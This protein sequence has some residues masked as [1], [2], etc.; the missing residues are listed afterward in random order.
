MVIFH[1]FLY[2]YQGLK[3]M[4]YMH[5]LYVLGWSAHHLLWVFLFPMTSWGNKRTPICYAFFDVS[6][7]IGTPHCFWMIPHIFH[8][9]LSETLLFCWRHPHC[10][11]ASILILLFPYLLLLKPARLLIL[12]F[13]LLKFM[14]LVYQ[15]LKT[16]LLK[17][18]VVGKT[19][20]LFVKFDPCWFNIKLVRSYAMR[21]PP[22]VEF[23]RKP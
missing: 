3:H 22:G 5:L 23:S 12:P 20:F 15:I 10:P 6:P 14:F 21:V 13:L 4:A 18:F 8:I 17:P 1:S 2:V 9:V 7:I 19:P 16:C 11:W